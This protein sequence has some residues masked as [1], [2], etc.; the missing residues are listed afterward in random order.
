MVQNEKKPVK[1]KYNYSNKQDLNSPF[2][3]LRKC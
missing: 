2:I 1:V 3:N